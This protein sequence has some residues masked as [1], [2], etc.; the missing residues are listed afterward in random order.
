M[1]PEVYAHQVIG[2]VGDIWR[3]RLAAAEERLALL[4]EELAAAQETVRRIAPWI[5]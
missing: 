4:N 1:T 5:D 3:I 2:E